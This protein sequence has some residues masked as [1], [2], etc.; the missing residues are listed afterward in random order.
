MEIIPETL[1]N[2]RLPFSLESLSQWGEHTDLLQFLYELHDQPGVI[3][4]EDGQ[5]QSFNYRSYG[6]YIYN[7]GQDYSQSLVQHFT[8][9]AQQVNPAPGAATQTITVPNFL[10]DPLFGKTAKYLVAWDSCIRKVMSESAFFSITHILESR[11]ELHSSTDLAS[12]LYYKQALQVLRSFLEELILPIHFCD[13]PDNFSE[14]K[15]NDYRTPPLRSSKG[16]LNK[17]VI[18]KRLSQEIANKVSDLYGDLNGCIHGSEKWLIHKG[19]S[20]GNWMGYVF[21]YDE[22]CT[23]CEYLCKVVD[24]GINLL[25]I[26]V[27]QWGN[28]KEPSQILCIYCHNK[29]D[30]T[31]K[32]IEVKG[33]SY[34]QYCCCKCGKEMTLKSLKPV[35]KVTAI[36]T[37]NQT[38]KNFYFE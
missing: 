18:K 7:R 20:T 1:L 14:W 26:N 27:D 33:K 37:E 2:K 3:V 12:N 19:F 21:K 22:F 17:L 4:T 5:E 9:A 8:V 24:V 32:I 31:T 15:S 13:H 10:D 28:L 25:K 16:L 35:Y 30:F 34:K 6:K 38:E 29:K 23:W 36:Q 11:T